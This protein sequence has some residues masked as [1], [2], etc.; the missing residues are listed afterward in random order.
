MVIDEMVYDPAAQEGSQLLSLMQGAFVITSGE[1]GKLNPEDV[2]VR[3]PTTTIG[4]RGT[5]Y[6]VNVDQE[7]GGTMITVLEGT[8]I[9][10]NDAGSIELNTVGQSTRASGY[11]DAPEAAFSLGASE[12]SEVF[13]LVMKAHP[14]QPPLEV[15]VDSQESEQNS[16]GEGESEENLEKLAEALDG[17]ET[18]AGE[19]EE[20]LT[21]AEAA[22][23][24]EAQAAAEAEAQAAAEAEAQAAAEAEAEME[25]LAEQVEE[26]VA[27]EPDLDDLAAAL[28]GIETAAGDSEPEPEPIFTAELEP[29]PI[30]EAVQQETSGTL[31]RD[32]FDAT[33]TTTTT[34][35]DDTP[36]IQQTEA[37]GPNVAGN[38]VGG[39]EDSRI[40]LNIS[41][42]LADTDGGAETLSAVTIGNIPSG[43]VL[44]DVS[45][46][47]L[48]V[49]FD[50]TTG[51]GSISLDSGQ[52]T[53]LQIQP[54][55]DSSVDFDLTVSATATENIGSGAGQSA[56]STSNFTVTVNAVGDAPTLDVGTDADNDGDADVSG[57]ENTAIALD[58]SSSLTDDS[59]TLSVVIA[60]V[61]AGA[62]LSAGAVNGDGSYT[63]TDIDNGD[64]TITTVADQLAGL[65]ITSPIGGDANFSLTVTATSSDIDPNSGA[66]STASSSGTNVSIID[67]TASEPILTLD[68]DIDGDG[69]ADV[70]GAEDT[71]IDLSVAAS[72]T[73]TDGSETLSVVIAG[74]PVGATLSAGSDNGNGTYTFTDIVNPDG[75]TTTV[76][77]QLAGLQVTPAADSGEDF[78]LTVTATSTE[79]D[80]G[81]TATASGTIDV[82]PTRRPS[83]STPPRRA[84]RAPVRR[85][86]PRTARSLSTSLPLS[87]TSMARRVS[88][89]PSVGSTAR[90]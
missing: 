6:G 64:G 58:I 78:E 15:N 18:A 29:E 4:I 56:T 44:F 59:E 75:T 54:P 24:A 40:D 63:I 32:D 60:G 46:N 47:E 3:T 10:A 65:S 12:M 89:S 88:A 71:P 14:E 79:E 23:E 35:V 80:G 51:L 62:T 21:E 16:E 17:V 53:G 87:P 90:L 30:V 86:S 57:S 77:D 42:T 5:K 26:P 36:E 76:A 8:V 61:P 28:D 9:V 43:S 84:F 66:T 73:D 34:L 7:G 1:I 27:T 38:T 45:G 31:T 19:G 68:A 83:I 33:T 55:A 11:D 41:A 67:Q 82:M 48:N 74:V 52:L 49:N 81:A 39:D 13:G 37:Q 25:R 20:E 2:T 72:L 22:A 69:D 70:S 50:A 85:R